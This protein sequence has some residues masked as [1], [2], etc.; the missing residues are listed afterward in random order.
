MLSILQRIADGDESAIAACLDEYGDLVWRLA[1]R[2][3]DRST[4]DVEDAVQEVFIQVWLSAARFDPSRGTEPAFVA[5]IAHRRLTDFQRRIAARK[6]ATQGVDANRGA[7]SSSGIESAAKEERLG[8]AL[9]ALRSLP[10]DER[11]PLWLW[12]YQGLTH[13]EIAEATGTPVGTVKSRLR[14]ALMRLCVALNPEAE[15]VEGGVS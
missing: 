3:L 15:R 8:A 2:Y 10:E 12:L 6:R 13:R 9:S 14:R 5:T 11:H 1:S 4:G 7:V